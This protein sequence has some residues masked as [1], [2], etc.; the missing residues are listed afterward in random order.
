MKI[1]D[2]CCNPIPFSHNQNQPI[3]FQF[4]YGSEFD[5]DIFNAELCTSCKDKIS[6]TVASLCQ[7][8]VI[9]GFTP[10]P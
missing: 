5:G 3:R 10:Q 2:C 9:H 7:Y 8:P 4:D 6:K 1:C